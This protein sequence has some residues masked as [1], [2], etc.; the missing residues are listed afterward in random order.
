MSILTFLAIWFAIS[1][2]FSIA[3]GKLLKWWDRR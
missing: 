3:T 2:P 1:I